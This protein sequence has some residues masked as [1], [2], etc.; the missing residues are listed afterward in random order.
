MT[1]NKPNSIFIA[2]DELS[3]DNNGPSKTYTDVY[4]TIPKNKQTIPLKDWRKTKCTEWRWRF[5]RINKK[6]FAE[7]SYMNYNSYKR[8]YYNVNGERVYRD[9]S[10]EWDK[11]VSKEF[12]SYE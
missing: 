10:K 2:Q 3:S 9:I 11:Y 7:I 1:D 12:Y 4:D 6:L 5:L 8:V